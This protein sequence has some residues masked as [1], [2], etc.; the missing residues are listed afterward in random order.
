MNTRRRINADGI[1]WGL[2]LIGGGSLLLLQRLHIADYAWDLG[3]WWPLFIVLVGMSKLAHR[4]SIWSGLWLI[5]VGAWLG[6]D[7]SLVRPD[8]QLIVALAP[9]H[10]RRRHDWPH[11]HRIVPATRRSGRREPS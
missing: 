9:R 11:H 8:L 1:F 3:S 6:R 4:R 2:L 10:P 5:A 7:A